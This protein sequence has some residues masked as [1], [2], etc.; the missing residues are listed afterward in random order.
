VRLK[1][2]LER[3]EVTGA[4]EGWTKIEIWEEDGDEVVRSDG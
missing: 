4:R 2:R 3:L 1:K